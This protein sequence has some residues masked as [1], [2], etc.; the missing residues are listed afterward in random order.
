MFAIAGASAG[1]GANGISPGYG[2]FYLI[3]F[4]CVLALA[5]WTTR[6]V[7]KSYG[8]T[9]GTQIRIVDRLP[10]GVDRNYLLMQI[11]EHHY[12]VYQDRNGARLLDKLEGFTPEIPEQAPASQPFKEI[13]ERITHKRQG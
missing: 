1:N 12:F 4:V 5:Y 8:R 2:M 6:W 10:S 7:S 13:L 11:G 9:Y 3:V